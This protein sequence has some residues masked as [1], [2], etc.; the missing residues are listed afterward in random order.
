MYGSVKVPGGNRWSSK[1]LPEANFTEGLYIGVKGKL[2]APR[3]K[4]QPGLNHS[5]KQYNPGQK[6]QREGAVFT[7]AQ[8]ELDLTA[9]RSCGHR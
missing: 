4:E 7:R 8:P 2:R 9:I 1:C 6:G 3:R 5:R